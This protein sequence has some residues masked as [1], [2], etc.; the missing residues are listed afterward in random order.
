MNSDM[1]IK[2]DDLYGFLALAVR[3]MGRNGGRYNNPTSLQKFMQS[4]RK[5][6]RKVSQ[7]MCLH[8]PRWHRLLKTPT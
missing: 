4:A 3:N 1:T 2:D 5:A 7:H 8:C 6:L